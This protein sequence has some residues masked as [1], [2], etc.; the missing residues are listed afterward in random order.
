[1]DEEV[2]DHYYELPDQEAIDGE[3]F[4]ARAKAMIADWY[5]EKYPHLRQPLDPWIRPEGETR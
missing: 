4:E 3:E 1:M 5:R 2:P